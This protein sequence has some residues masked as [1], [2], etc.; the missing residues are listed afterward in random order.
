M[1]VSTPPDAVRRHDLAER[2]PA[3]AE[4]G[5]ARDQRREVVADL[6]RGR[7][8]VAALDGDLVDRP[9]HRHRAD[10]GLSAARVGGRGEGRSV[11]G[12]R[13]ADDCRHE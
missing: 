1:K 5:E 11:D 3:D 10:A 8:L 2:L 12:R 6:L 9:V 7:H 4:L 13:R